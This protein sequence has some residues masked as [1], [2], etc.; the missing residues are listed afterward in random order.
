MNFLKHWFFSLFET[1]LRFLPFPCKTGLLRVGHPDSNAP[2]FLTGNYH[3][4]VQRVRRALRGLDAFLV[5]ANSRGINVWCAAAG[6]HFSNHDVI[7]ALKT[8]GIE[9]AVDHRKV[10]LPQLSATGIETKVIAQ[11]TGWKVI[12]GPVYAKD[13]SDFLKDKCTKSM[14]MRE[15]RFSLIQRIEMAAAWAFPMSVVF[16]LVLLLFWPDAVIESI[17]MVWGIAVLVFVIFPLYSGQLIPRKKKTGSAAFDF[18]RGGLQLVL[19]LGVF[20]GLCVY[21]TAVGGFSWKFMLSWSLLSLSVILVLTVDLSGTTPVLPSSLHEERLLEVALDTQRCRGAGFC[22]DV[23]PRNCFVVDKTGRTASQPHKHK[24][25]RCGACIGQ[26]PFDALCFESD[27]GEK[28]LPEDVRKHKLNLFGK[29]E[30][31]V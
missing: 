13:I 6:G 21:S 17:V 18:A 8:S 1:L 4:T 16:A 22:G 20:V 11:R 23:C 3:L 9:E 2:V 26:C 7:S 24:C 27:K 31:S 19:W 28:I 12:W 15:V 5:V 29:R 30:I 25:V 14:K 10:I